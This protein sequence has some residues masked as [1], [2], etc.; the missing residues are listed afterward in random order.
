M[1]ARTSTDGHKNFNPRT[2]V[3]CDRHLPPEPRGR[4]DFNPRTHVGCDTAGMEQVP[5]DLI[6]QSTHPRG[7]RQRCEITTGDTGEFQSTHPRGVRHGDQLVCQ[8]GIVDFNP[9]T[10]VGCDGSLKAVSV[11]FLPFQSTHPRGVRQSKDSANGRLRRFQS[12]HPRGVRHSSR[13]AS[14][15]RPAFQSTHPRGVRPNSKGR[16]HNAGNFNP[17]TH[18]GCD[19][20]QTLQTDAWKDFNPRTHVGCD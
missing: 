9:R 11:G 2:H 19:T 13:P 4:G 1:T 14:L 10:H 15:R 16:Y 20:A 7:V 17:R 3:G 18:V 12:T 6:F 8:S 5:D